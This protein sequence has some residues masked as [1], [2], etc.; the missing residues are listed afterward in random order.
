MERPQSFEFKGEKVYNSEELKKYDVNY[1]YGCARTVRLL[2]EK[3]KISKDNYYFAYNRKKGWIESHEKYPRAKLLLKESWVLNNVPLMTVGGKI[4]YVIDEAPEILELEEE[5][6]FKDENGDK[7]EIEVRGDRSHKN[8]YFKVSDV[9]KGFGID[10]LNITLSNN[11]NGYI[12]NIHYKT[13]TISKLITNVS[14]NSK[15]SLFLTYNGL[16]RVLFCSRNKNAEKFQDWATEKLFT[17]QLGKKEDREELVSE[18]LDVSV[19]AVREVFKRS[20][21]TLPCIYLFR[22][23]TVKELRDSMNIPLKYRDEDIVYK[24]G[25]TKD[26]SQRSYQHQNDYGRIKNVNLTLELYS[27]ID[28]QYISEAETD[29]KYFFNQTELNYEYENRSEIVIIPETKMKLVKKQY[30]QITTLYA[31]HVK[32]LIQKIKDL[33]GELILEKEKHLTELK[34]KELELKDKELELEKER[35]KNELQKKDI[36]ILNYKIKLLE[37][38]N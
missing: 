17:I 2:I 35:H 22:L 1:F 9:S 19:K 5:E 34:N 16:L 27:Y 32:E 23:N 33:E 18:V 4:K 28:P 30:N 14:C 8:C 13:F 12:K 31:G 38:K 25:M 21:N 29:I 24:Y 3:K 20:T 6:K 36:E 10:S 7:I 11:G 15:K 37:M 26:L